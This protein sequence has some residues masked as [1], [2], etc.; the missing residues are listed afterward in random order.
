MSIDKAVASSNDKSKQLAR[1]VILINAIDH[2]E[3]SGCLC[4]NDDVYD[5]I[6][7]ATDQIFNKWK[8]T[9]HI[10]LGSF[11]QYVVELTSRCG[12]C[13][14]RLIDSVHQAYHDTDSFVDARTQ[15]LYRITQMTTPL[16]IRD[17]SLK[18]HRC[19]RFSVSRM[20]VQ[21]RAGDEDQSEQMVCMVCGHKRFIR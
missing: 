1:I 16:D 20:A 14:H 2:S 21:T 15:E 12:G 17:P 19:G 10:P 5:T 8:T 3:E 11:D 13:I 4:M 6:C 9:D 18:C 7:E